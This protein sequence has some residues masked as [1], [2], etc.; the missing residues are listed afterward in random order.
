LLLERSL[1]PEKDEYRY[2]ATLNEIMPFD[3]LETLCL[4]LNLLIIKV[5]HPYFFHD[6]S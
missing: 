3:S 5:G 1:K 4:S 6:S 2:L